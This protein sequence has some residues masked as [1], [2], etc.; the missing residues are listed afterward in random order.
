MRDRRE[1]GTAGRVIAGDEL[2]AQPGD[3]VW[4]RSPHGDR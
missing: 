2:P 1:R 3:G 4:G